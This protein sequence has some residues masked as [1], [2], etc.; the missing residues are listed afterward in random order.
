MNFNKTK[1]RFAKLLLLAQT[2]N[3]F[4][5][6]KFEV[7]LLFGRFI[8][9]KIRSEKGRVGNIVRKTLGLTKTDILQMSLRL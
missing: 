2:P 1:R 3:N 4:S 9:K 6:N 8:K 7:V 5:G